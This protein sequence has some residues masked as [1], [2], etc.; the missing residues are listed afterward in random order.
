MSKTNDHTDYDS[1]PVTYCARCYS[2]KIKHEDI[3]DL[4]C[5]ADCGSTDI[6][7][8]SIDDWEKKY[9]RRYKHKFVQKEEDPKKTYIFK[10][11]IE[12]LK[13]MV[14]QNENWR[15]II[16]AIYPHFPGGYS[17]ADSIILFFDTLFKQNKLDELRLLL[18]KQFKY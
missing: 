11:S 15:D 6:L 18:F 17:K 7:E 8:T 3:L 9:E 4:D 10:L 2:L 14:Y 1:E 16:K 13:T 5:C 12:Q